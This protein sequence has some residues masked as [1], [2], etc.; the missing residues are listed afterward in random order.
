MTV[1]MWAYSNADEVELFVNGVSAGVSS[2]GNRSHAS[3]VVPYVAGEVK[4]VARMADGTEVATE[5]RSTTGPAAALRASIKEGVGAD[6]SVA[7][8][9]GGGIVAGCNDVALVQVQVVDASGR[10]VP[11]ATNIIKF[12]VDGPGQ[13]V[14][15]GNG[16]PACHVSDGALERP[17]FHGLVLGIVRSSANASAA[18]TVRVHVTSPGLSSDTIDINVS[19]PHFN[20]TWWCG[21]ESQL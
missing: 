12:A 16:D 4:A 17:A 1:E 14:G 10:T 13:Y 21:R 2:S 3:W 11:T 18:G 15:G 6:T 20:S 7:E 5:S 8:G 19:P 9:H